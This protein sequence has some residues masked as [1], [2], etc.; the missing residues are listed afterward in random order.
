VRLEITVPGGAP[1]VV[2]REPSLYGGRKDVGDEDLHKESEI[3]SVRR[4]A[5]VAI[6]EVF[7][8]ARRQLEDFA[9]EQRGDVKTHQTLS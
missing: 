8:A 9:R 3:D 6:H 7:D 5:R 2:S 1:I 4:H